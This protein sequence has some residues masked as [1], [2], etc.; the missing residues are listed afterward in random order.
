MIAK[1]T[2]CLLGFCFLAGSILLTSCLRSGP[3]NSNNSTDTLKVSETPP[4]ATKEP[5]HYKAVRT[6]TLI[7]ASG[8]SSTTKTSI[9]RYD[10][11]RREEMQN[12]N[13]QTVVFLDSEKGRLIFL[14]EAKIFA[15]V[16]GSL[17]GGTDFTM[18]AD[19]S[20]ERLLHQAPAAT[21]YQK[22][23]SE[24][25]ASRT[26]TKYRAVV[27]TATSPNV[28]NN[29]TYIWI[30]ETLG[31]PVKSE[32]K[33]ANGNKVLMDLTDIV[34]EIDKTLF[35]IPAGY[36]KVALAELRRQLDKKK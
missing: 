22:L 9:A 23:G 13:S 28:S 24:V 4:F 17:E 11:L 3:T 31:M 8:K 10:D 7:D 30:D 34:L 29:E 16:Q 2:P 19:N 33:D 18:E 5:A 1:T 12:A 36:E 15:D 6:F 32:M 14:P 25:V 35:Q 27:N 21:A 20:P 26:T